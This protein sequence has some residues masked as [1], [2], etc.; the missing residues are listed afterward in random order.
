MSKVINPNLSIAPD[1][2]VAVGNINKLETQLNQ[3]LV[4]R[5][6]D[7][8]AALLAMVAEEHILLLGPPGT[9]KSMLAKMLANAMDSTLFE[10]L[11]S[12]F[13][14]PEEIN[15]PLDM[16]AL[17]DSRFERNT[18]GYLP[19]ADIAFF[20]EIFKSNSALLNSM[21]TALNERKF[22]N[23]G[24]R[25]SIPLKIAIGASNELPEDESLKA[26]YDRFVIR[27]WV[28]YI[29]DR[30]SLGGLLKRIAT[31]SNPPITVKLTGQDLTTLRVAR[32]NVGV[33][34]IIEPLLD[35]RDT[36]AERHSIVASDRRWGKIIK[37][38][39]ANAVL[40]GRDVATVNDF[41]PLADCLWDKP[42]DR[43]TIFTAIAELVSPDLSKAIELRDAA[44][45]MFIGLDLTNIAI[46][47][48]GKMA[49]ANRSLMDMIRSM[50]EL[51]QESRVVELTKEIVSMQ[52]T[53]ATAVSKA[54][55]MS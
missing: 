39:Q 34:D 11:L 15:G 4:E 2:N 51:E 31:D 14:T 44:A 40:D 6:D 1:I 3:S 27:R 45:E 10:V 55:H 37:F 5:T 20:D 47:D 13:S 9:A 19:E 46:E 36:L 24:K 26:L 25:I 43:S 35:L 28:S 12:K 33:D 16:V 38:I 21:L 42:E 52:I 23:G 48:I 22:D 29:G 17:Q 54:V 32:A 49:T 50:Q 8:R 18:A 53:L 7:I 30:D 41:F